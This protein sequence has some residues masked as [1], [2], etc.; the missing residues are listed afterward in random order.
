MTLFC[1]KEKT[2]FHSLFHAV[3]KNRDINAS[4]ST[5]KANEKYFEE[6]HV[7]Y[8]PYSKVFLS[9]KVAL[10]KIQ[11]GIYMYYLLNK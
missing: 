9:C 2:V 11:T 3:T 6:V 1:L 4:K 5:E 8:S 7:P 10:G